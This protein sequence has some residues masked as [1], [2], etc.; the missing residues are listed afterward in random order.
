MLP[1]I[2]SRTPVRG[3]SELGFEIDRLFNEMLEPMSRQQA[4]PAADLYE[5]EE[6][7]QV[8]LELPGF[9][10]EDV[11]VTLD[12]GMLTIDAHRE[13]SE[14]EERRTFHLRERRAERLTRS[15]RLPASV[16]G[17]DVDASL[18]DG[19]LHVRLPKTPEARPRRIQVQAK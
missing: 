19:I 3:R 14:E 7:Y 11:D 13:T 17:D 9:K 2:I 5:T 10:E 1:T 6:G 18:E 16:R 8:D 4:M 15:F 12:Q